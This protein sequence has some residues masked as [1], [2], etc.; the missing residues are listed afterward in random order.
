MPNLP[1]PHIRREYMYY[2]A[3]II[4]IVKKKVPTYSIFSLVQYLVYTYDKS[5][6]LD[7]KSM[8]SGN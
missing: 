5:P 4:I 1:A 2:T 8:K 6:D 3:D 7:L